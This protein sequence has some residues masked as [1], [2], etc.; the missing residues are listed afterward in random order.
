MQDTVHGLANAA[1]ARAK[2][3]GVGA[4]ALRFRLHPEEVAL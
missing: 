2:L 1:G 3:A 4:A